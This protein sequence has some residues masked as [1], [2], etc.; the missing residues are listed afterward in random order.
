MSAATENDSH[1]NKCGGAIKQ[2]DPDGGLW[3]GNL[4]QGGSYDC[5]KG[6]LH[7]PAGASQVS[8]GEEY[9]GWANRETWA[10]M[11][12]L[13]NEQPTYERTREI[14]R[15]A[16]SDPDYPTWAS[17][18]EDVERL[19]ANKIGEAI[20]GYVDEL[21]DPD[22]YAGLEVEQYPH[23]FRSDVGSLWR[24]DWDEIGRN[25]LAEIKAEV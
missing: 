17:E 2:F 7:E 13:D 1:C 9:N 8:A 23:G 12:W 16:V 24:V 14:A 10:V 21:F 5:P 18:P 25:L 15:E 22:E 11:L 3:V 4:E 6:G 20:R 19:D